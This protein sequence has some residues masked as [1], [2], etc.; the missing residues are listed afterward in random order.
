[1]QNF[2]LLPPAASERL[3]T[4]AVRY[5]GAAAGA[6]ISGG[7]MLALIQSARLN[8]R[9]TTNQRFSLLIAV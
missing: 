9:I 3:N 8:V 4:M 1:V 7:L 6:I 5:Y 2:V